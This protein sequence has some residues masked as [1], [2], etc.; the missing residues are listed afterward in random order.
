MS[1]T[2]FLLLMLAAF[3][4]AI[5]NGIARRIPERD[6]FFTLILMTAVILYF[7]LALW[8]AQTHPIPSQAWPWIG[9]ST[10]FEL[11][12]FATLAK[13]YQ[14]SSFLTA[15]PLA[16]GSAPVFATVL[17]LALTGESVSLTGLV[18]I[19]L[20]SLGILWIS[21]PSFSLT[22]RFTSLRN[23]GTLW[24]LLT[25]AC[26]ASY[27][28]ADSVGAKLM[29]PILFKYIV[30]IGIVL[31][32]L[33]YD[34]GTRV[35]GSYFQLVKAYPKSTFTGGMLIFGVNAIIVFA[36]QT[37]PVAYVSATRETSIV[38]AMLIGRIWLHESL[39][40]VKVLAIASIVVGILTIKVSA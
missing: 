29:S 11:F 4:H 24:A 12:Y 21:Q 23:P 18:G 9:A 39:G 6:T 40:W 16:R 32:K 30:F 8:L 17:S 38:F 22:N 35:A 7:P 34:K 25:G 3:G 15:Y 33:L 2:I 27:S 36:L 20:V 1:N 14:S 31:G 5:W 19:G 10:L 13:A 26:T 28:V 37:T